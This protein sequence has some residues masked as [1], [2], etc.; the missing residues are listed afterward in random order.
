MG[1]MS[2]LAPALQPNVRAHWLKIL[3]ALSM[4]ALA[5]LLGFI[6]GA[7]IIFVTSGFRIDIVYMA[8]D[9][10]MR[11]AFFKTRGLS[12]S[13]VATTPYIFLSLGLALGFK[14]GLFN[15]GVEGQFYIGAVSAAW[16][17]AAF[18]GLP[19]IVHLPLTILAGAIG[20]AIWAGIPGFLKA[21]TGAHEVIT[22]MM[23]N[24]IAFRGVEYLVSDPLRDRLSSSVQ[25]AS[26]APNAELWSFVQIPAR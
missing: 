18:T 25:T 24:Y 12:E 3:D 6:G 1:S 22:T 13:L 17:G 23:M 5:T 16:I 15:I 26:V 7:I 14:A 8:F 4:P 20:G 10:M 21:R 11:G 9:G 19:A 2:N